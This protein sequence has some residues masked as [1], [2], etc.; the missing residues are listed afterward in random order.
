MRKPKL[1]HAP[2][3]D[4]AAAV[5]FGLV[6][7]FL[8]TLLIGIIQFAIFFWAYQVGAHAAREGAR[9]YAVHPCDVVSN[10]ALVVSRVGAAAPAAAPTVTHNYAKGLGNS[11]TG[12]REV[13]DQVTVSVSFSSFNLGVLP[14]FTG[15]VSK[16][17]TARLENIPT[18]CTP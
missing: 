6:A 15:T 11:L 12:V 4:G 13:G 16:S 10:D 3:E 5:E 14:G 1:T 18:G 7:V 9:Q 17:A 2:R 8:L